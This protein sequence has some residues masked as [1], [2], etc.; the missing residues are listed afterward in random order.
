MPGKI[1][2]EM[3]EEGRDIGEGMSAISVNKSQVL[4]GTMDRC[5]VMSGED[6]VLGVKDEVMFAHYTLMLIIR[7]RHGA[8]F[9]VPDEANISEA[10]AKVLALSCD[11]V[12]R[13]AEG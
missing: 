3:R 5:Y 8:L 2:G 11:G 6:G 9:N 4:E 1:I 10:I 13:D 12:P 7:Y